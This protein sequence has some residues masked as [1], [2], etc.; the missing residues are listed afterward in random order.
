MLNYQSF[1]F[2]RSSKKKYNMMRF[3]AALG[4]DFKTWTHTKMERENNLKEFRSGEDD[5]PKLVS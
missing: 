4:V 2:Y 3:H 5:I 1:S